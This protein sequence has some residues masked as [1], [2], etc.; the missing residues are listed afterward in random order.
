MY[1]NPHLCSEL[2]RDRQREMLAQASQQRLARQPREPAPESAPATGAE[3]RLRRGL[4]RA[5]RLQTEV[6]A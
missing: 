1:A 4:R 3:R 6:Q 5:L 2:A